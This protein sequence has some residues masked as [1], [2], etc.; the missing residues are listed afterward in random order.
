MKSFKIRKVIAGAALAIAAVLPM[1]TVAHAVQ[2]DGG[3]GPKTKSE[4]E[5]DGYKCER[6][7]VNFIVCSKDGQK[8][9]WCDDAGNCQQSVR[10]VAPRQ[11]IA[12]KNP[13]VGVATPTT[14]PP[15][16]V[17][18]KPVSSVS[19]VGARAL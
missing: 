3:G 4:L 10:I 8:D 19:S 5:K 6:V 2:N 13:G 15:A 17:R 14:A 18:P 12:V 7:S 9:Y 16:P 11:P 1:A